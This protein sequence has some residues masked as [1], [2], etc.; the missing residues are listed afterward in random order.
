MPEGRSVI[1]SAEVGITVRKSGNCNLNYSRRKRMRNR[2]GSV[3]NRIESL[4]SVRRAQYEHD[5]QDAMLYRRKLTEGTLRLAEQSKEILLD[6]FDKL[7]R[8]ATAWRGLAMSRE[9]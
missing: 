8:S 7:A 9:V 2:Q 3:E 1:V 5:F 6:N 4:S